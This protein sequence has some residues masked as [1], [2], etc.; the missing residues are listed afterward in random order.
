[1]VGTT[2]QNNGDKGISVGEGSQLVAINNTISGNG[3]GVQ[4]KDSSLALLFNQTLTGND[5]ALDAYKK[6]WRYGSGGTILVTKS[7]I[8]GNLEGIT[9]GKQ[10]RIKL[11]DSYIDSEL[12]EKRFS[13]QFIDARDRKKA[14][15]KWF[16]EE[17]TLLAPDVNELLDETSV[18][19][20]NL[21]DVGL[22]GAP[23]HAH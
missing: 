15:Q 9:V 4:S 18:D 2:L 19:L 14:A 3:F 10:S 8:A 17:A 1:V 11:F 20:L 5:T 13:A 23:A 12:P 21:R 7:D 16:F 6:N 22:R